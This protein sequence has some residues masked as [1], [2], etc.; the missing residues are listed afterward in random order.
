MKSKCYSIITVGLAL[1]TALL[2]ISVAQA[3]EFIKIGA[4]ITT[5]GGAAWVGTTTYE[6]VQFA[7]DEIN[8]NG[9]LRIN[10]KK[11]KIKLVHYDDRCKAQDAQ[12]NIQRLIYNDKVDLLVTAPCSHSTLAGMEISNPEKVLLTCIVGSNPDI[13]EKGYKY[14]FRTGATAEDF[15][16]TGAR[17]LSKKMKVKKLSIIAR[18]DPWGKSMVKDMTAQM[19]GLGSK[20]VHVDYYESGEMDFYPILTKI[21]GMDV[22]ATMLVSQVEEGTILVKQYKELK[23]EGVLIGAGA[24]VGKEFLRLAGDAAYGLY[25]LSWMGKPGPALTSFEKRF[26]EKTGKEAIEFHRRGYDSIL[27]IAEVI[28]NADSFEDADKLRA[29]MMKISYNGLQGNYTFDKKGQAQTEISV[30]RFEKDGL[31]RVEF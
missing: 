14:V 6:G 2:L 27:L 15:V 9:G 4:N 29:A 11:V 8:E 18:N 26:K 1:I 16:K 25:E 10:N 20:V 30:I 24:M 23:M 5:S 3:E 22:D 28:K 12:G 21:K 17:F 19:S 31:K 13:T 7:V